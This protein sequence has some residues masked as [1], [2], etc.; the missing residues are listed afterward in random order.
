MNVHGKPDASG[1][2]STPRS[3][4]GQAEN[5]K[6]RRNQASDWNNSQTRIRRFGDTKPSFNNLLIG[7]VLAAAFLGI[8]CSAGPEE[9]R[10]E[11]PAPPQKVAVQVDLVKRLPIAERGFDVAEG[12]NLNL[13]NDAAFSHGWHRLEVDRNRRPA[14]WIEKDLGVIE[15]HRTRK[16]ELDVAFSVSLPSQ[17]DLLEPQRL[18]IL[19][20]GESVGD[21]RLEWGPQKL[22]VRIPAEIQRIGP[23]RIELRPSSFK[24]VDRGDEE[25]QLSL[26]LLDVAF[27]DR[28]SR[29][30]ASASKRTLDST[31]TTESIVQ[32][33]GS[34]LSYSL[35]LP[36]DA[37][38][39]GTARL[40]GKTADDVTG[41]LEIFGDQGNNAQ[42]L[43][44]STSIEPNKEIQIEKDLS[45]LPRSGVT[46]TFHYNT[47]NPTNAPAP[48]LVWNSLQVNGY[49]NDIP[50]VER[51]DLREHYNIL[52]ILFDTLRADHTEPYGSKQVKT[53]AMKRL[54]EA[55]VTFLD[56]SSSSSWT[57]TSVT[58]MLTSMYPAAHKTLSM[59]DKLSS[60]IPYLPEILLQNGYTT[61]FLTTNPSTG[62]SMGFGRGSE[63]FREFW[64]DR[65]RFLLETPSAEALAD[66]VWALMIDPVIPQSND[67][68]PFFVYLH[69]PDPHGPY[70]P[71][72]PYDKLY[73]FGYGDSPR[74]KNETPKT[75]LKGHVKFDEADV[76][77]LRS[78]YAGEVS[79]SDAY[80]GRLV[81][82][83]DEHNLK[84]NTLVIVVS[85]HGEEFLDHG[86]IGHGMSLYQEQIHIPTLFSLPGTLPE[87]VKILTPAELIDIPPTILDLIGAKAPG[88]MAGRSLL[89]MIFENFPGDEA[90]PRY[91]KLRGSHDAVRVGRWKMI[92]EYRNPSGRRFDSHSLYDLSVDPGEKTDQWG[93]EAVIGKALRQTL[94]WQLLNSR[95]S[96]LKPE[97]IPVEELD[98]GEVEELKA[99]GYLQEDS[100]RD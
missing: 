27:A 14:R 30:A 71:V 84:H 51:A 77:Y 3:V 58:S 32:Q 57:R 95:R 56:S 29:T 64:S 1:L 97:T 86:S 17:S 93:R 4:R 89:P 62:T 67:E 8:S 69:E 12:R 66:H 54:A 39:H 16:S 34:V 99:L 53:P 31:Q 36:P 65:R 81:E 82:L 52:L 42:S 91:A 40:V 50:R 74:V 75:L 70:S 7:A 11:D 5:S 83:L 68:R 26:K 44:L 18:E 23:N 96:V 79:F 10:S 49:Q 28:Q 98:P 24:E 47:E 72:P 61:S 48:K 21:F 55:G 80:L 20:N 100:A 15:L 76:N 90:R 88:S 35:F 13:R 38:L 78:M 73:N 6:M 46:L 9:E 19:W 94:D 85:D 2:L 25:R 92:R 41:T 22:S 45:S 63:R 37:I 60:E 87:D 43:L 59:K 33:P